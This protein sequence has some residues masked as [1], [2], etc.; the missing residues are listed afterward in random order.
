MPLNLLSGRFFL[1]RAGIGDTSG[2]SGGA[3]C[4]SAIGNRKPSVMSLDL[5][6]WI[7]RRALPLWLGAGFDARTGT[8]WEALDHDGRPLTALPRRLRVQ[9]RCAYCFALAARADAPERLEKARAL[10]RFIMERGFDPE[11]GNLGSVLGPDG[12][13]RTARHD[14]YDLAFVF[15]AAAALIEAGCDVAAD[16]ARLEDALARLEAPRGWHESPARERPRRQNPHM[17]MLEAMT[18]LYKA[19]GEPRFLDRAQA[20]VDLF[21]TAFLQP[22][23]VV[24]EYFDGDWTA[25]AEGQVVEPGHMAEWIYLI[26]RFEA[27][28]GRSTGLPLDAVF[29]LVLAGRDGHGLLLDSTM[30]ASSTR[31]TWPQTE[32]LKAALSLQRR[33]SDIPGLDALGEE[34]LAALWREYLDTPVPGGWYDRRASDGTLLSDN[35]PASTFYHLLVAFRFRLER[36]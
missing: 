11:T 27:V 23:G 18:A 28:T 6:D 19:T 1:T 4:R 29:R 24:L 7:E 17:H 21:R 3:G 25:V 36:P 26:E 20:C 33:G 12:A 14:L 2:R 34:I 32:F 15:L 5:E 22:D 30:P 8:V 13:L 31:R 10:F 9:A 35:M 16:L